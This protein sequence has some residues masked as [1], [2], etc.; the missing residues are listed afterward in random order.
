M[1]LKAATLYNEEA[2][3]KKSLRISVAIHILIL[4]I[5]LYPILR[6]DPNQNI[7]KQYAIAITFDQSLSSNSFKGQAKEGAQRPLNEKVDKVRTAPMKEIP[8]DNPVKPVQQPKVQVPTPQT[9]VT[10]TEVESD[11]FEDEPEVVAVEE[12][13]EVVSQVPQ[14][15]VETNPKPQKTQ[16]LEESDSPE[17]VADVPA[18]VPGSIKSPV[19]DSGN[20]SSSPSNQNG[21]GT[22]QGKKGDGAGMDKKGNGSTSGMGTGGTG[23]GAFD[24]S[25]K[26]IFGRQPVYRPKKDFS[27]DKNGKI[28]FKICIDR[29]G[30]STFVDILR[31]GTTIRDKKILRKATDYVG[32]FIWEEDYNVDKEQCG[33]YTL[34]VKNS[35]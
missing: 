8:N 19:G 11:I 33:K 4:L 25:G 6:D 5:A 32:R 24:G 28:V 13:P 29:N 30:R 14:Q 22:G 15:K 26:G 21:S 31:R 12:V 20:N 18:Q 35:L 7:D 17:E 23:I 10:T 1:N 34:R 27:L 2:N 3:K 16:V 9:P